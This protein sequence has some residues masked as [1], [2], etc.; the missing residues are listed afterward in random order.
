MTTLAV[1]SWPGIGRRWDR[2][3]TKVGA[4]QTGAMVTEAGR[5]SR[6]AAWRHWLASLTHSGLGQAVSALLIFIA[7]EAFSIENDRGW[8]QV[9]VDALLC[10]FAGMTGRWP[11]LGGVGTAIMLAALPI[12]HSEVTPAAVFAVLIPTVTYATQRWSVTQLALVAWYLIGACLATVPRSE[13]TTEAVQTVFLWVV[14][15]AGFWAIGRTIG[16]LQ[17]ETVGAE[18][19]RLEALRAQRRSIARDLHDTVAYATS[20]MI[21]RAEEAKLRSGRE[22]PELVRDLDFI[23]ATGRRSVR[24][25]RS[26]LEALRRNDPAFD[27]EAGDNGPWRVTR[28][29]D[30]LDQRRAE[31][32]QHG[33]E[34]SITTPDGL[35]DIPDSAREA[36]GKL[37][38]EATSNM[39]K[40]A[41]PPGPCRIMME[42]QDGMME[43]V[44]T[45]PT[46]RGRTSS[47]EGGLGL[48][49][50]A[51]RVEALGG[52]L[53]T[54][55][56]A[57][58]WLLRVQLPL[59]E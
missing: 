16:R 9:L 4:G 31:L 55:T 30:V 17:R 20:T 54:S 25:L 57:G 49:G 39:V 35:D 53:E 26:M 18:E 37:V 56:A 8:V 47:A 48:L 19:Q 7:S 45:N 12:V 15:V 21:M 11:V 5:V 36:L 28:L 23:I 42:L 14:L 10:L 40:H 50:A 13:T 1:P 32:E 24:D 33:F 27:L 59:G 46:G 51:E 29:S 2:L 3:A 58:M 44:F 22:D 34:V 43:A 38:V 52:E 41:T 6:V